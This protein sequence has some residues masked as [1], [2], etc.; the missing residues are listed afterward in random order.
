[1]LVVRRRAQE[2]HYALTPF[3][4]GAILAVQAEYRGRRINPLLR[5]WRA[6]VRVVRERLGR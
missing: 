4:K 5:Y 6:G 3:A 1:M 2:D